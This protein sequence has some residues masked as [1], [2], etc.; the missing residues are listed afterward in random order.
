[1]T[2]RRLFPWIRTL[3]FKVVAMS[4]GTAVLAAVA[5]TQLALTTTQADLKRLVLE[6][7]R[8]DSERMAVMLASKLGTLKLTLESVAQKVTAT[9]LKDPGAMTRVLVEQRV[10]AVMFDAVFAADRNG[11]MIARA[12]QGMSRAELLN[13][14]DREYFQQAL[15]SDNPV[16]SEALT[17]RVSG[18]PSLIV[19]A[20]VF[21]PGGRSIGVVAGVVALRSA[22]LFSNLDGVKQDDGSRILVVS[23][24]GLLLA[25]TSTDRVLGNAVDEPG[26]AVEFARWREAGSAVGSQG[27]AVLSDGYLVSMTSIP[28]S[29]WVLVKI[30]PEA[31][32]LAPVATARRTAWHAAVAAGL[33]AALLSGLFAWH[34]T[35][36]ISRLRARAQYLLTDQAEAEDAWPHAS[37]EVGELAQAF[38]QVVAQR[39]AR[40]L[41]TDALLRQL[42]AVL[43]H[44]DVGIALTRD[45]R[46]ELVSQQFCCVFQDDRANFLGKSIRTIYASGHAHGAT[47]EQAQLALLEQDT[48]DGEF[49]LMRGNGQQFWAR[50]RG[51]AVAPGDSSQ[52]TIWTV[53]DVTEIREKRERLLRTNEELA[54][55]NQKL[56]AAQEQ[57][58][59]SEKLA[60][61]GQ[62]A[63]GV[64]HEIN[65]PVGFISSNIKTLDKYLVDVFR[66]LAACEECELHQDA[67]P[68]AGRLAALRAEVE[69]DY[70][71]ED[72]PA[73]M[74]ETR[75]G[76]ERVRKIVQDLKDFSHVD[77]H[78][79]WEWAD[80]HKGID[81][82][83]NIVNSEIKYR[84][85]VVKAYGVLPEV[86]CLPF[87]LNQVFMNL[88]VNAAHAVTQ[89]R[90]TVTIR[91]G[92][93]NGHVWVEVEDNGC[94]IPADNLRRIFDPFFTTKPVGKGT[95][96]GLS[97]SYGIVKKHG[98]RIDVDSEVGRGTRFRVTIPIEQ[99]REEG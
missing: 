34:L 3:K 7:E 62:L 27:T 36:P 6:N 9:E 95:G 69:L 8:D 17:G 70:L 37:G 44:A 99:P 61:I 72:I 33:A 10:L 51:R 56:A 31:S 85:E 80:L 47:S 71:K 28:T 38:E 87:E 20:P 30:T 92:A 65:N 49:E 26:L 84:A 43:D 16:V 12:Q 74:D 25:H 40:Q 58:V 97:L 91:T 14:A 60:S 57:L 78:H 15:Q 46:F 1:M 5:S 76:L 23:R 21:G 73:L 24:N 82:T 64:A 89:E 22:R 59:Q 29:D 93:G 96:L 94:G 75:G 77:A 50:V 53:E 68:A 42:G 32:A 41:E 4:V 98:G 67:S 45:G 55:L 35:R 11:N 18:A 90:G 48:F 39:R 19:A 66:L 83:L 86:L 13:I 52:G 54:E 81:S 2:P 63:A 79:Q 88:L